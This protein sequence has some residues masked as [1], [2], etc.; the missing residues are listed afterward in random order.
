M[1]YEAPTDEQRG[2]YW[3]WMDHIGRELEMHKDEAHAA[4]KALFLEGKSSMR[5]H[6]VQYTE[7]MDSINGW[8]AEHGIQLPEAVK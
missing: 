6:R 4:F 8:C 1:S 7:Y 3:V 2:L 5:L